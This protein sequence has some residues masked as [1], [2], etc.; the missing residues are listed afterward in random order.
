M[1]GWMNGTHRRE[2]FRAGQC[3]TV[4]GNGRRDAT[5]ATDG[6]LVAMRRRGHDNRATLKKKT[7]AGA[8]SRSRSR[9]LQE[10]SEK[11]REQSKSDITER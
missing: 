7:A 5:P 1:V 11:K 4:E 2:S 10:K 8:P 3:L 9:G 6:T